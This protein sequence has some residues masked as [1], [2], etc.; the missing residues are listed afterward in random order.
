MYVLTVDTRSKEACVNKVAHQIYAYVFGIYT[1]LRQRTNYFLFLISVRV[2]MPEKKRSREE[3]EAYLKAIL[4][5]K[6]PEVKY[7]NPDVWH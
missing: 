4:N 2:S 6:Y 3:F 5:Q 7:N 1:Y